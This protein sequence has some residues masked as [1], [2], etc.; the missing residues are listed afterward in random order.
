MFMTSI[1]PSLS[2]R[3]LVK[4][5]KRLAALTLTGVF[6]L[7]FSFFF[8]QKTLYDSA[9]DHARAELEATAYRLGLML[10]QHQDIDLQ[11]IVDDN[12]TI[13]I[14]VLDEE[15]HQIKGFIPPHLIGD[16]SDFIREQKADRA[17]LLCVHNQQVMILAYSKLHDIDRIVVAYTPR[18]VMM[19]NWRQA[20]ILHALM[21]VMALVIMSG[22]SFWLWQRLKRQ[23]LRAIN[24][25]EHFSETENT[26]SQCGCAVISWPV[27]SKD[28]KLS[29]QLN[30]PEILGPTDETVRPLMTDFLDRLSPS[31]RAKLKGPLIDNNWPTE[32]IGAM[33]DLRVTAQQ[34]QRFYLMAQRLKDNDADIISVLLLETA[35]QQ[36]LCHPFETYLRHTPEPSI[37]VD[38]D[39][40]LRGFSPALEEL[41][42]PKL[43]DLTGMNFFNL[44]EHEDQQSAMTAFGQSGGPIMIGDGQTILRVRH[45]DGS[46]RWLAWRGIG[47]IDG[48]TFASARDVTEFVENANKLRDTLDQLKRSNEDLEQFAYV[49]SHDLQQP[50]RMVASYTQL[51]KRRYGGTLDQEADEYIDYA[52]DGAKRMHKLISHL[53]E[54][55]KTGTSEDLTEI[56]CNLVLNEAQA[57]LKAVISQEHAT[58]THDDLP[59]IKGDRIALSRLFQN[60]LSNAIKYRRPGVPPHIEI[61]VEPD[62]VLGDFWRFS[63]RD[64]GIGIHPEH[65][66]RIFR[67]FQRLHKDEFSGT[68]LG[69]SL[70]RKIVEQHGGRI[71]L[72]TSRPVS[73]PGTTIIFTLRVNRPE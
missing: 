73:D 53:L 54:Y 35:E 66:Q 69:L 65:A 62:P 5:R 41:I 68:G 20:I 23:H 46:V 63:V 60:L 43:H 8:I 3:S 38:Q 59:T 6:V 28:G 7:L 51:L 50:L 58:I 34:S 70:C 10:F 56:D 19:E 25:T 44:F 1:E 31:S 13:T 15:F 21:F 71:W 18:S 27:D 29:T 2:Q 42:G 24:L 26:L 72:D 45:H 57:D 30:W 49:A 52:V 67:L 55:A 37:A 39:G 22:L 40:I 32:R 4:L 16:L 33:V 36:E 64:N 17:S 14:G 11:Q 9:V 48:M 12:S 47:P 61:T